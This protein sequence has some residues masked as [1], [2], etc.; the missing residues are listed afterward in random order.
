[1]QFKKLWRQNFSGSAWLAQTFSGFS[2]TKIRLGFSWNV[3]RL[4][5]CGFGYGAQV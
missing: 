4:N 2:S 1:M 5:F 3:F